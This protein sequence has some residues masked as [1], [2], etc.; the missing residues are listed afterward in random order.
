MGRQAP[1]TRPPAPGDVVVTKV[2][3]R[4]HIGQVQADRDVL[5]AITMRT[6]RSD[7]L[8]FAC[9]FVTGH[10]RVFLYDQAH[11]RDCVEIDCAKRHD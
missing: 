8:A 1:P 6:D 2:A 11:T 4:Y 5:T 9:R 10:Q 3:D 7:A